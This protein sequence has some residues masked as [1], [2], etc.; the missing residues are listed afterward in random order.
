[1]ASTSTTKISDV[2]TNGVYVIFLHTYTSNNGCDSAYIVSVK[3]VFTITPL[4]EGIHANAP[5]ITSSG[6]IKL[7][8]LEESRTVVYTAFKME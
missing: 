7:N 2:L 5:Q 4:L 3:S 8:A 1:M 6:V